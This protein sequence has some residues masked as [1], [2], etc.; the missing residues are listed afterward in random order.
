MACLTLQ[1]RLATEL[2]KCGQRKVWLDPSKKHIIAQARSREGIR[3]LIAQ[4]VIQTKPGYRGHR[5]KID[6]V[7]RHNDKALNRIKELFKAKKQTL[8]E[9]DIAPIEDNATKSAQ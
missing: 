1:K 2:L 4:D 6:Q 5:T 7:L 8:L 9:A 3:D